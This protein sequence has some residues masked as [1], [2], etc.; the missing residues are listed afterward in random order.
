MPPNFEN[1][2]KKGLFFSWAENFRARMLRAP[3]VVTAWE[4]VTPKVCGDPLT[5]WGVLE[6]GATLHL[7]LQGVSIPVSA[8][9][10]GLDAELFG[11]SPCRGAARWHQG[12]P[13]RPRTS[14]LARVPSG[15][16]VAAASM[17]G[18]DAAPGA[19][20]RLEPAQLAGR[21]FQ[22]TQFTAAAVS[23]TQRPG[24]ERQPLEDPFLINFSS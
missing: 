11:S 7:R 9:S 21:C 13:Q 22:L 24:A 6:L 12:T 5:R 10:A 17:C 15:A 14:P 3:L 1:C 20:P 23:R 19:A 8:A 4:L 2:P 16:P 18:L